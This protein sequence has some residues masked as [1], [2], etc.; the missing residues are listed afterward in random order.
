M[1][2]SKT[3][4]EVFDVAPAFALEFSI[5]NLALQ[6]TCFQEFVLQSFCS[7]NITCMLLYLFPC[8]MNVCISSILGGNHESQGKFSFYLCRGDVND[9][10]FIDLAIQCF[11]YGIPHT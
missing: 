11:I 8:K 2:F 5:I 7:Q 4:F 6:K 9:S 1:S 3:L 10:R